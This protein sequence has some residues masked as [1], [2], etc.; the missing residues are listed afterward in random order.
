MPFTLNEKQQKVFKQLKAFVKD[1]NI[2]TFILN[3]YAGTGKTFLIQ[4]FAKHL[5]KEKIKFSL[6]A[7]TGRAAAVLRGKTGLTTSTV[8][9][10]LYSFSKVD[11]DD[12]EIPADAPP[13]AFGQMRLVFEPNK[14]LPEDC[15]YIVDEASMLASDASNETSFA[16]F[17]SGSLLPDLLDAIGNNKI[18]FVGDPCQLPP[19]FQDISPALD[20]NWLNDF[21]RITV[22]ATLDEI[23]RTNKDNDIL[24]V[25]A[26]VRQSVGVPPPTKWIKMPARNKNNCIIFPDANTLFLEYYARFLQYGPTD[27]IA[28]AHS[29][30]ACNH[31]NK[32]LRKR[33]FPQSNNLIEEGEVLMVTQNNHLV[34]LT[35]GDFVKVLQLGEKSTKANLHFQN[36]RVQHLDTNAEYEIKIAL[37][38]FVNFAPNLTPDQQ[39]NLMIEF[40]RSMRKKKYSSKSKNYH[41]AMMKDSYLNSLR[42]SYGYVVTCHKAQGGEWKDVF[43]FLDAKMYGN[44]NTDSLRRWWYT[45]ITRTKENLHLHNGWWLS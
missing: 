31:L 15:V 7:T 30:K 22:E 4:Q 1:K 16:V 37:D 19:V 28:I 13:D 6:L 44:L 29:N 36:A 8:H 39:R 27:S 24:D 25:A 5:E 35:N 2:N 20:K 43:L 26:Q 14:I 45:A 17:G 18:I 21:G 10:A 42:A 32:F 41:D 33:L 9:G 40:A 11:G 38:P 23:M 12:D 3:G 34:P